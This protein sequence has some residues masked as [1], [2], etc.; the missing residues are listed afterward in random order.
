MDELLDKAVAQPRLNMALIAAF[1]VLALLLACVGVYSIVT[2][3]VAQRVR[4]IGVRMA[5]GASRRQIALFFL[6]G[7]IRSAILGIVTGTAAALVLT[8]LLR[9]QLYGVTPAN[10]WAYAIS[11]PL[12][13]LPV[14]IATLRPALR[15][16][17]I[18]PV[19][20]L[21]AD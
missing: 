12:L 8:H 19:D 15:A 5:L 4:E 14:L 7:A 13:L 10:P 3:T 16:A 18:N 21:R 1:A 11:I 20:A 6:D 2:W 17:S 9:S